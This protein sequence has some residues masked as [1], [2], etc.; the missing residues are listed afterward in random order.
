MES[1]L[2]QE[3]NGEEKPAV[4]EYRTLFWV[5]M[6]F[7]TAKM[8][9]N[10]I[11]EMLE[12]ITDFHENDDSNPVFRNSVSE[13]KGVPKQRRNQILGDVQDSE[14]IT[15]RVDVVLKSDMTK[16][17][18]LSVFKRHFL[19]SQLRDY[20]LDDLI[21]VMQ[22]QYVGEG[23][24]II[25]MGAAGDVFYILEEGEC[26]ILINDNSLGF[27]EAPASFGDLALMYNCPRAATIVACSDCTLWTLDR[28]FFRQAMVT[29]S[30][31][32]NVQL[33]Q[34]LSKIALFETLGVQN[35]N[36]LARSLTKQSFDDGQYIIK[37]GDIGEQFY[38]IHKGYVAV[39]ITDDS[40]NEQ[41]LP[42]ELGEG[43]VFGERA[44]IKKEPRKANCVARGPVEVY[45]LESQDFYS[46]LGEFVETF[47]KINEFRI[48]RAISLFS[49]ISD[50]R[51]KDLIRTLKS[52]RM[53]HGQRVVCDN[54]DIYLVM[55]G[56]FE[57]STGLTFPTADGVRSIGDAE[58]SAAD[59]AGALT[60]SSDEGLLVSF[61][62]DILLDLQMKSKS[63]TSNSRKSMLDT[64]RS[65][66]MLNDG[67]DGSVILTGAGGEEIEKEIKASS[68]RR[69]ASA[70]ARRSSC[71]HF[72]CHSLAELDIIQPLGKGTFGSVYLASHKTS[73]KRMALKCLDKKALVDSGQ[74]HYVKREVIALQNFTHPFLAQYYGILLSA[75]KVFFL[76][77]F[78]SG[79]EMW[80]Y[81]YD[82]AVNP[83]KNAWGGINLDD[84]TNYAATVILALEHIHGLGYSYRDL[85]PENLLIS[86][87][88]YLKLVD[89]G[90]A[91]QI[92]F[93]NKKDEVQFRS[94]TLCGTPDYMA[95]ELVLTQGHDK[96]ID[97]W[98]Y[99]ILIYEFICGRTPFE[100]TNQQR[101]FEKIVHSQKHLSF[102]NDFNPHCK[103]L[104]RRLLHPNAALRLGALQ[105]GFDDIKRHAFFVMQNTDFD[106][107]MQQTVEMPYVPPVF[108]EGVTTTTTA[109]IEPIDLDF[110]F[111]SVEEDPDGEMAV[112]FRGLAEEEDL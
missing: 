111:T 93:M 36:Q 32:Q 61:S 77:E 99:G 46:M 96:S 66:S 104:I 3:Q 45:F 39:S 94:F 33:T 105:N 112:F 103:S 23:E 107:L 80:T 64:R 9:E 98:A 100:S 65:S 11:E 8:A 19:F 25:E 49:E 7:E 108:E 4:K 21:D 27:I 17:N 41:F 68:M 22:S 48:I 58:E 84:A 6:L 38:V 29:S 101:T 14:P 69:K 83:N 90:F 34:F 2:A 88:G 52:H 71:A 53:F 28:V 30:S 24:T 5:P 95:P 76:L 59:V 12:V 10:L 43:E 106:G 13:R 75:H 44:L 20:E 35:I 16:Y 91:K 56:T 1:S 67:K 62:R 110:E 47:N 70:R 63:D 109:V 40:G 15:T 73:G 72:Q 37:Q 81:I 86:E 85:K 79:G 50:Y 102:P 74:H 55:E 18:L 51:L 60:A 78:I 92:P 89:F 26:E 57:T 82:D 87:N 54:D 31:N 42:Y 97:Y